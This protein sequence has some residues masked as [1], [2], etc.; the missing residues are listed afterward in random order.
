MSIR[1]CD[2]VKKVTLHHMKNH[3]K[4]CMPRTQEAR[5]SYLR[6]SEKNK[7][8]GNHSFRASPFN[9]IE[10]III[11][12]KN[13]DVC[14][15]PTDPKFT[16][17]TLKIS[18]LLRYCNILSLMVWCS[19]NSQKIYLQ[20]MQL[21]NFANNFPSCWT[22]SWP[23]YQKHQY[24]LG[25]TRC[26]VTGFASLGK[27]IDSGKFTKR[28]GSQENKF[29]KKRFL[30]KILRDF[31]FWSLHWMWGRRKPIRH[32]HDFKF[33]ESIRWNYACSENSRDMC[34]PIPIEWYMAIAW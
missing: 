9:H 10:L 32:T 24:I 3:D 8:I 22:Y 20:C 26:S 14:G 29:K 11:G 1:S 33:A 31:E 25:L 2:Q 17:P 21:K 6:R 23:C 15:N 12:H 18:W 27:L 34:R 5:L 13:I 16:P 4:V 28:V 7:T 30:S 19:Q